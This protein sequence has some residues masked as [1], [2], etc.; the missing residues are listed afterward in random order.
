MLSNNREETSGGPVN[1]FNPF[2]VAGDVAQLVKC[3]PSI[4]EAL[5]SIPSM[6]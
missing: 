4:Q 6:T 2:S 5:G 1:K 3:L